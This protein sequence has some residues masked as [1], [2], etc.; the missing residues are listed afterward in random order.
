MALRP[1]DYGLLL[2]AIG[3]GAALGPLL[4]SR[5]TDDPRRPVYVLG[6]FVLRAAVDAVLATVTG[7]VAAT[8]TL[9]AYGIGTST[10]AVTFNSLLRAETPRETAWEGLRR[11]RHAL[12]VRSASVPARRRAARRHARYPRRLLPRRHPPSRR[13]DLQDGS[14]Y[15]KRPLSMD[16]AVPVHR[17]VTRRRTLDRSGPTPVTSGSEPHRAVR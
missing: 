5:L 16:K 9:L 12:A 1:S 3:V 8:S 11:L 2:G 14:A 6:P 4:L 10:G 15:A 7:L 13:R 17:P